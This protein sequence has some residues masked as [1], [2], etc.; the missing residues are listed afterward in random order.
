M[1]LLLFAIVTCVAVTSSFVHANHSGD[2][3]EGLIIWDGDL[4][5]RFRRTCCDEVN[6][7]RNS[8]YNNKFLYTIAHRNL[9]SI[10]VLYMIFIP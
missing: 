8:F 4:L 6:Y 3:K 9:Y 7:G 10:L 5:Y 2:D 1:A